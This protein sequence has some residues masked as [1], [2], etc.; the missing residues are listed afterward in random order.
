MPSPRFHRQLIT[1]GIMTMKQMSLLLAS[2]ALVA[3][4]VSAAS[5]DCREEIALLTGS[6]MTASISDSAGSKTGSTDSVTT[7]SVNTAAPN[8]AEGKTTNFETGA[9]VET[10]E[11][12]ISKDGSLAPLQSE[13]DA[14]TAAQTGGGE[15]AKL[16]TSADASQPGSSD[17]DASG[18]VAKD[19]SAMP[20]ETDSDTAMS[21]QDSQAQ[22]DGNQTAAS[23]AAGNGDTSA[24]SQMRSDASQD[25]SP[26]ARA[27][28]ALAEGDEDAC[29]A[30]IEEAKSAKSQ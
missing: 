26:L 5:A 24:N 28:L 18:K 15:S 11:A 20:M 27:E 7:G 4:P 3:L 2:A 12:E 30:A 6:H 19:G 16:T 8:P 14:S 22:Q 13:A 21:G 23:A 25:D 17:A 29:M 9:G 10:G 1:E